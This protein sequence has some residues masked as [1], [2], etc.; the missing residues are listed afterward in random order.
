M[1]SFARSSLR[2]NLRDFFLFFVVCVC[3]CRFYLSRTPIGE[4]GSVNIATWN[5]HPDAISSSGTSFTRTDGNYVAG[6]AV[7]STIPR[8]R[9]RSSARNVK[10][11]KA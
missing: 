6:N 2:K 10:F 9:V 7:R 3:V 5:A 11:W 8:S 1:L 4:S